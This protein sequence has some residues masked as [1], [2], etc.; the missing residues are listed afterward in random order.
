[1]STK[2]ELRAM[3]TQVKESYQ[4][5]EEARSGFSPEPLAGVACSADALIVAH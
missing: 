3:L 4:E 5:L 1:M 2:G